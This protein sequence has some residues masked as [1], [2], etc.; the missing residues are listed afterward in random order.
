LRQAWLRFAKPSRY[1]R[2]CPGTRFIAGCFGNHV[3]LHQ[4]VL[5][6]HH[7]THI[8]GIEL[9][10]VSFDL[11]GYARD[12]VVPRGGTRSS[13][14]LQLTTRTV[15]GWRFKYWVPALGRWVYSGFD[16]VDV[17]RWQ[18]IKNGYRTLP[19]NMENWGC[20]YLNYNDPYTWRGVYWIRGS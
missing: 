11:L 7:H 9:T 12:Y 4:L 1:A 3:A 13:V 18:G 17:A 20:Y 8:T 19:K 15:F 2:A 16:M 14:L 5:A 6:S 10:T